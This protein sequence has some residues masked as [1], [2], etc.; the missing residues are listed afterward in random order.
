MRNVSQEEDKVKVIVKGAPEYLMLMCTHTYN[1][2]G[3][4]INLT[5]NERERI[6]EQEIYA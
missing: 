1:S 4:R 2:L 6:L 3:R 5:T